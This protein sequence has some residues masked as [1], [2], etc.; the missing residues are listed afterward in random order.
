MKLELTNIDQLRVEY[1]ETGLVQQCFPLSDS[2]LLPHL[3]TE[4]ESEFEKQIQKNLSLNRVPYKVTE[5]IRKAAHD[6]NI[7]KVIKSVLGES[8]PWV[9]WGA[10]IQSG[11]PNQAYEWHADFESVRFPTITL[12]LG[13][14]GCSELNATTCIPF[15]QHLKGGPGRKWC[16]A[17]AEDIIQHANSL[18]ARCNTMEKFSDFGDGK[19]YIFNA[20]TWH[21]GD[22]TSSRSRMLLIMHYQKASDPRIPFMKNYKTADWFSFPA[23]YIVEEGFEQMANQR[24][25]P[26]PKPKWR[27]LKSI[28]RRLKNFLRK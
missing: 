23:P 13:L 14:Q 17:S 8:E 1:K 25:Y 2:S 5:T 19:F 26:I 22:I 4:Y 11:T 28:K 27:I 12:M 16:N 10:N 7:S 15:S 24:L 21:A 20:K 6:H 18:D 3:I 9:M